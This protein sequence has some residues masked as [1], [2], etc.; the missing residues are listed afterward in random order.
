MVLVL[1]VVLVNVLV[2]YD[3]VLLML[4]IFTVISLLPF[5][6][7]FVWF[8]AFDIGGQICVDV[9]NVDFGYSGG[10][11]GQVM[12]DDVEC[13]IHIMKSEDYV[14]VGFSFL[15]VYEVKCMLM[16]NN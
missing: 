16:S 8:F 4:A 12:C 3:V 10:I 2:C 15:K 14:F 1:L 5:R 9:K 7:V 6:F 11:H 13:L